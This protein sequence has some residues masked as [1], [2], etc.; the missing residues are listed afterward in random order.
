MILWATD[1]YHLW[2]AYTFG[3]EVR[4]LVVLV[5]TVASRARGPG[6]SVQNAL[7]FSLFG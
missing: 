5:R 6:I 1:R 2:L 7:L 3:S 4:T